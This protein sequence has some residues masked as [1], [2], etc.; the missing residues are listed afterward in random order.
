MTKDKNTYSNISVDSGDDDEVIYVS[1]CGVE[2]RYERRDSTRDANSTY[3]S[4][5]DSFDEEFEAGQSKH[6]VPRKASAFDSSFEQND[7]NGEVPHERM[8]YGIIFALVALVIA[9]VIYVIAW[10]V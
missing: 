1:E 5:S 3:S 10:G 4:Y 9:F 6:Q 7:L 8:K 2:E